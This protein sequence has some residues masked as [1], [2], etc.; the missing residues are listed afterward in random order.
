MKRRVLC[1]LWTLVLLGAS[2]AYATDYSFPYAGLRLHAQ[3]DWTVLIPG[4]MEEHKALLAALGVDP[5]VLNADYAANGTV[6]EVYMPDSLQVALQAAQTGQS[7]AWVSMEYMQEEDKA[8]LLSGLSALPYE[9]TQWSENL[10]GY[11]QYDWTVMAG[12]TPVQF[13]GLMT[14]RQ[15]MLYTLTATSAEADVMALHAANER[16]VGNIDFLNTTGLSGEESGALAVPAPIGDDDVVTPL[17]LVDFSA[18]TYEDD[19]IIYIKTLPETDLALQTASDTLRGRSDAE[20]LHRFQVSTRRTTVYTYTL[21]AHA[22]GRQASQVEIAIERQLTP[23]AQQAAYRKS[24]RGIEAYGYGNLV[25]AAD[26]Y[27]GSQ[28][29]FRGQVDAFTDME[30]FPGVLLYTDNPARGRWV[31]PVWVMLT[32]AVSL[33]R[34]GVYTIYGDIRGDTMAYIDDD[35]NTGLAPVII[36]REVEE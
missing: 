8:G 26:A 19:T 11:L 1:C 12:G 3:E 13:A 22:T 35:G 20:G 33:Q 28:V 15:G 6:F 34:E 32:E 25:A 27:A 16:M 21:T 7:A 2:C 18:V 30:G 24:A 36:A 10:P 31:N 14:V 29:T 4:E 23:E 17:A 9:H 5:A